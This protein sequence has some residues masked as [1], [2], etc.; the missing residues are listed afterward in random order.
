MD[1]GMESNT[2]FIEKCPYNFDQDRLQAG[3]L[4]PKAAIF[5]TN[6]NTKKSSVGQFYTFMQQLHGEVFA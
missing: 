6:T 2:K 5:S 1:K 3:C 4:S